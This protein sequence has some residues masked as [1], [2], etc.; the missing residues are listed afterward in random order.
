[1]SQAAAPA[2]DDG[3]IEYATLAGND[4]QPDTRSA[5]QRVADEG[6]EIFG[7]IGGALLL[8][9]LLRTFIFQPFTIPSE[10]MEPNLYQGD[11]IVI[12]KFDYGISRYSTPLTLP[13][14]FGRI[15]NNAPKRGDIVVFKI[16]VDNKTDLIKRVV[17]L[18]ATPSR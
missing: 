7:V 10:S 12:T 8:V 6:K 18:P 2:Y 16:P 9:C 14:S 1:M 11:Y 17:G 3:A 4:D 5:G 15:F 13:F